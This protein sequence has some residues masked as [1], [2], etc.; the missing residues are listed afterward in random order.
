[1]SLAFFIPVYA[2]KSQRMHYNQLRQFADKYFNFGKYHARI[3]QVN[4]RDEYKVEIEKCQ[5]PGCLITSLKVFSFFT[6][7]IPLTLFFIHLHSRYR[8]SFQITNRQIQKKVAEIDQTKI[9]EKYNSIFLKAGINPQQA[10]SLQK[11]VVFF[12]DENTGQLNQK[13]IQRGLNR[14]NIPQIFSF[15][16][17]KVVFFSLQKKVEIKARTNF[18]TMQ[19]IAKIGKHTN[20]SGIYNANGDFDLV[21][22][23]ALK[24][25]AQPNC[26]YLTKKDIARMRKNQKEQRSTLEGKVAS[27]GEFKLAFKLFGDRIAID[28]KGHTTSAISFDRLRLMYETGPYL[29]FEQVASQKLNT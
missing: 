28:Q 16:G 13:S 7:F 10:T 14:L 22:F 29:I 21:Q 2:D 4:H 15:L 25:F 5:P 24:K 11:H 26:D 8:K 27:L 1:M 17:A 12:A 20:D 19:D 6:G 23:E 9:S 3:I 18:L